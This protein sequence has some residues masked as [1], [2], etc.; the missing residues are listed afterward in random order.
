MLLRPAAFHLGDE[1]HA[2]FNIRAF[3][4]RGWVVSVLK[5]TLLRNIPFDISTP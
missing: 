5:S 1:Q 2:E 3:T 4:A